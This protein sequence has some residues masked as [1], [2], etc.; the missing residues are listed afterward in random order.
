MKCDTCLHNNVCKHYADIRSETY[1]YMGISFDPDTDCQEYISSNTNHELNSKIEQ[2][3]KLKKCPFCGGVAYII[4]CDDEGN[5]HSDEYEDDPW[6]GLGF[7]LYHDEKENPNCPIAHEEEAQ[8]G[9]FIYDSRKE[10]ALA[11]NRRTKD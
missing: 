7:M 10:A 1:A 5:H 8:C 2:P 4:V 9:R 11:W 3:I 6:S